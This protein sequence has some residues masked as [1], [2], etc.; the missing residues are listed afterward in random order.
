ML[1]NLI[2]LP[3]SPYCEW[4]IER[5]EHVL[6]GENR[7]INVCASEPKYPHPCLEVKGGD[8]AELCAL[9]DQLNSYAQIVIHYHFDLLG[10]ILE[11]AE[12]T[13]DRVTWVL[14][15][16]DLYNTPFFDRQIYLPQT[17]FYAAGGVILPPTGLRWLKEKIKLYRRKPGYFSYRKSFQ[18]I[19]TIASIFEMDV[20]H[21]SRI[22]GRSYKMLPFALLSFEELLRGIP[23]EGKQPGEKILLG[24]A[25][26]P[27]NNHLEMFERMRELAVDR[28]LVCP[29]S[30]GNSTYSKMVYAKGSSMFGA[31]LE[32]IIKFMPRQDYY[33]KL[34]EMGFAVFNT[35]V[36]QA[37]GNILGLLYMGVKVFLNRDNSIYTQL[38]KMGIVVFSMDELTNQNLLNRLSPSEIAHNKTLLKRDFAEENIIRY[39]RS[40][41]DPSFVAAESPSYLSQKMDNLLS[42]QCP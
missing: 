36:Q 7:Y 31:Q 25:G 37:F 23:G 2:F 3:D 9:A 18:R 30:Y 1:K 39:Y 17:R 11:R 24:H 34:S 42:I 21:A 22:F 32:I 15:S 41:L 26:V 33:T 20:A 10:F 19:G 12:I 35:L 8:Y 6:P 28:P 13:P 14:W 38:K 29:L 4:I 5:C 27:E 40:L 16:G